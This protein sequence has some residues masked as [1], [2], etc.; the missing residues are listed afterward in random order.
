VV[1]NT[2]CN[3]DAAQ[4]YPGAVEICDA[5]DN[6]C[7]GLTD[8]D[9]DDVADMQKYWPDDDGDGL[10][11][12]GYVVQ[13][14]APGGYVDN[15]DDC[16]DSDPAITDTVRYF[17]DGDGDGYGDSPLGYTC[18][19]PEIVVVDGDCDDARAEVFPGGTEVCNGIDDNCDGLTDDADPTTV[20]PI[21]YADDDGD[22]FGLDTDMVAS[23]VEPDGYTAGG[24]DC[25][26]AD[27]FTFPD[28]L[29]ALRH[30][31]TTTATPG[32]RHDRLRRLVRRRRRRRLRRR[33]RLGQRLLAARVGTC[34]EATTATTRRR[35]VSPFFFREPG[36]SARTE[37][38]TIANQSRWTL[39]RRLDTADLN[40]PGCR[41]REPPWAQ[42]NRRGAT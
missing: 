26:D 33:E 14:F 32:G 1:D 22:G 16:D 5:V 11:G 38:T 27:A 15:D 13:C 41:Q 34:C 28:A 10:G 12:S 3:D 20:L 37:S 29:R 30:G 19:D 36:R 21:W 8:E 7:D 4:R 23:C 6:D 40:R 9:D 18:P 35:P 39:A 42:P 24:G 2:D 17:A 25:D 31:S